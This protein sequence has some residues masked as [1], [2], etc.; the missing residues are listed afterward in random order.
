MLCIRLSLTICCKGQSYAPATYGSLRSLYHMLLPLHFAP[1]QGVMFIKRF[2]AAIFCLGAS[3]AAHATASLPCS[4]ETHDALLHIGNDNG[5]LVADLTI[6][7]KAANEAEY[8]VTQFTSSNIVWENYEV[9]G[10][11]SLYVTALINGA[12]ALVISV[13][14]NNGTLTINNK[15]QSIICDW[16]R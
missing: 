6:Y 12:T 15:T 7:N 9:G 1:E 13:S 3:V 16:Q 5:D 8:V 11:N 10:S 2:I 14:G 4:G